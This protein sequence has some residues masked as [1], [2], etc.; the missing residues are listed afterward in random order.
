MEEI[1]K[2]I[3]GYENLYQISNLGNVKSLNYRCTKKEKL[4]KLCKDSDGYLNVNLCKDGK[5]KTMKVHRLV[6]EAFLDN[7]YNLPQ[8]NHINEC[9]TDNRVENLE[10]CDNRYN[11]NYGTRNERVSIAVSKANKNNIKLSKKVICVETN[12]VYPSTRDIERQLGFYHNNISNCCK[13]KYGYKTVGNY[14]W[15]YVD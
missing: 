9:K 13:G 4:L 14:H 5:S 10:F 15:R 1:W 8:V 3:K 2:D 12:I 6:A 7:P 11:I